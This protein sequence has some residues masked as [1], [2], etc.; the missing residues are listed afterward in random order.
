[1]LRFFSIKYILNVFRIYYTI[2]KKNVNDALFP[3]I[4]FGKKV[5]ISKT[6]KI[7]IKFGGSIFIDDNT[8]LLDGVLVYTYGGKITIGK[9]CSINPYTIIY[10][11][12][13]TTIGN[14]VLIAGHCMIIPNNHNFN[15]PDA[16][17]NQQGNTKIGIVIEDDVWIAHSCSILDGITI[18]KGAVIAAGSVV[19]KNVEPYTIVGGIPAKIIK[20]RK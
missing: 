18:G 7:K 11:H 16:L 8:E 14:N 15:E 19:N 10:G 20:R 5:K 4:R 1:M 17:I 3:E 9:N 6:A 12:G 2:T 13:N